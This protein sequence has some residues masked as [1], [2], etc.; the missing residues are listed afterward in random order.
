MADVCTQASHDIIRASAQGFAEGT[1]FV[2]ADE[3]NSLVLGNCLSCGSTLA[4]DLGE[5][6]REDTEPV[7]AAERAGETL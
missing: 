4:Y 7:R 2:R 3:E 5:W 1:T 6:R